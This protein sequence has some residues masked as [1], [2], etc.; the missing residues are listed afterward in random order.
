MTRGDRTRTIVLSCVFVLWALSCLPCTVLSAASEDEITLAPARTAVGVDAFAALGQ[1]HSS[2]S[3]L[4]KEVSLELLSD[5]LWAANGINRDNGKRTAPTAMGIYYTEIYVALDRGVYRY[6]PAVHKLVLVTKEDLKSRLGLQRDSA[7]AF[8]VLILTAH[9]DE[10]PAMINRN[11][12]LL[13]AHA[14]A[15]CIA[16]NVY[17]AAASLGLGTRMVAGFRKDEVQQGLGLDQDELPLYVMPLG[18]AT[19]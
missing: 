10:F 3:F 15:G 16:Q 5:V 2:R 4:D 1:R 17:L 7:R 14:T 13:M 11:D 9:M 19:D 18:Y 12:A 6:E 8:A